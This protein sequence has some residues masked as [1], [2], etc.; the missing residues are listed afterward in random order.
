MNNEYIVTG[1]TR[2]DNKYQLVCF[3]YNYSLKLYNS[4]IRKYSI[5]VEGLLDE[6]SF[7]IIKKSVTKRCLNRALNLL[8][9]R[10]YTVH[11]L[12]EKLTLGNYPR[13]IIDSVI[14]R[15]LN[16]KFLDD[17]RYASNYITGRIGKA[18]KKKIILDLSNKGIDKAVISKAYEDS[19]DFQNENFE[20]IAAKEALVKKVKGNYECA[21]ED[22]MKYFAYLGRKGFSF[23]VIKKAWDELADETLD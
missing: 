19:Q 8:K 21:Y 9:S 11:K 6:E 12:D 13:D 3:N 23:E 10:D 2:L 4:E 1:I 16:E 5:E 17:Y 7:E 18:S 15:L 22:R 20:L 14:E